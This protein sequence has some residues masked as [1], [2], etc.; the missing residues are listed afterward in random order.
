MSGGLGEGELELNGGEFAEAALA[1]PMVVGVFDPGDHR[2]AKLGACR[3]A[4]LIQ[5][6]LLEQREDDSIAALSPAEATRPIDPVSPAAP[7]TD[8]KARDQNWLPLSL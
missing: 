2:V 5:H 4:L 6:V 8:T 1:A 7:R 3:P